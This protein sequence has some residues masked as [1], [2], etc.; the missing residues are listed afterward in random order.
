MVLFGEIWRSFDD[1]Q[2]NWMPAFDGLSLME[3]RWISVELANVEFIS[4]DDDGVGYEG[5]MLKGWFKRLYTHLTTSLLNP[6]GSTRAQDAQPARQAVVEEV[7]ACRIRD[8]KK[9]IKKQALRRLAFDPDS[10]L[11]DD[12]RDPVAII[13]FYLESSPDLLE[14]DDDPNDAATDAQ[15]LLAPDIDEFYSNLPLIATPLST[16]LSTTLNDIRT[17]ANAGTS[18]SAGSGST[19]V[20]S[21]PPRTTRARNRQAMLRS[22]T[23]VSL[24]SQLEDRIRALRQVQ[25]MELPAARTRMAATAA[26]VLATRAAVLERTVMLLERAKH[27]AMARAAKAKADHLVAVA[28]GI[29]GKLNV[30]KLDIL[31]T[32]HTPEVV[33]ALHRY[34]QHLQ[35]TRE[36]LEERRAMALEELK[37]YEDSMDGAGRG[38]MKELARQYGS[39]IQEVED[40]RMEIERLHV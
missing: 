17:I 39:L 40:V 2:R 31:A 33:G 24:A 14:L 11:P 18:D 13:T 30:T 36:R 15:V 9:Q 12:C 38:P 34:H 10:G 28:Q 16:I 19:P 4:S 26:E 8:A 5:S 20:P 23:Q 7:K 6:D 25:L 22:I 21:E 3:L 35:D 32:I 27:G 1:Q 29:E 37:S